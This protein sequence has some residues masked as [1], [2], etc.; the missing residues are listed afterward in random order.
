MRRD[1][2]DDLSTNVVYAEELYSLSEFNYQKTATVP[3]I[4]PSTPAWTPSSLLIPLAQNLFTLSDVSNAFINNFDTWT[5]IVPD[6]ASW[7]APIW[8]LNET[9]RQRQYGPT[10]LDLEDRAKRATMYAYFW[11]RE[12]DDPAVTPPL[13]GQ[14]VVS[15]PPNYSAAEYQKFNVLVQAV[16]ATDQIDETIRPGLLNYLWYTATNFCP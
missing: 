14:V 8:P 6:D 5:L 9:L 12:A 3:D 13:Y 11:W 1:Y 10:Q 7:S 15:Y 16:M 4:S 2:L